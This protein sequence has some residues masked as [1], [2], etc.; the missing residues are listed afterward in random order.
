MLECKDLTASAADVATAA[1]SWA[2]TAVAK[3]WDATSLA[4]AAAATVPASVARRVGRVNW[5]LGKQHLRHSQRHIIFSGL[6]M[7]VSFGAI[8]YLTSIIWRRRLA[9]RSPSPPKGGDAGAPPPSTLSSVDEMPTAPPMLGRE[10]EFS[11]EEAEQESIET[12]VHLS[13]PVKPTLEDDAV[14]SS[15][16]AT[17][18]ATTADSPDTSFE[19]ATSV[20]GSIF[21]DVTLA[22]TDP[23]SAKV[24]VKE[25]NRL[26]KSFARK[27]QVRDWLH[28]RIHSL[29]RDDSAG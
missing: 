3:A 12:D 25:L 20:D 4:S 18:T 9:G 1:G 19:T 6:S 21:G 2:A 26:A 8:G 28:A 10:I 5:K 24:R 7:A 13:T 22:T 11:S 29:T 17:T 14:A 27:K 23:D 15:A 16:A